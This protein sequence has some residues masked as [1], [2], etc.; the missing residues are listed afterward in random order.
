MFF[1]PYRHFGNKKTRK[2]KLFQKVVGSPWLHPSKIRGNP[3]RGRMSANTNNTPSWVLGR[4]Q[5]TRDTHLTAGEGKSRRGHTLACGR[6]PKPYEVHT[7]V[8][9]RAISL[10]MKDLS[11]IPNRF[12]TDCA[13]FG[14]SASS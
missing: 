11:L 1:R 8:R 14:N 12:S 13:V 10:V 5:V 9:G 4:P 7:L 3:S 2:T 6:G